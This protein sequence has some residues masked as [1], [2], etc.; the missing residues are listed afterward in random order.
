MAMADTAAIPVHLGIILDGNRRWAGAHGK[1]SV[2]GHREGAEVFKTVA[3]GAFERG[4]KYLSAFVFST[5]NWSRTEDE[6]GYLMKLVLRAVE[7]YL[8]EFHQQGIKIIIL[9]RREGV[10]KDVLSAIAKAEE[11]TAGNTKG[12]L[13]LCFNYG[14]QEE[15]V[16]AVKVLITQGT[17]A[18]KIDAA[19]LQ[20]A[21]YHPEVPAIDLI[22]RT[23]G[24]QRLSGFMLWRAAYAELLFVNKHWPDFGLDDLDQ[25]LAEY[26]KR[27]RRFGS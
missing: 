14:G 10:A 15:L 17:A 20:A 23:S 24:E 21:L 2:E 8:D 16:D 6:V 4:V 22:I 27:N 1:P 11:K 12:T 18:E 9:G 26:Q 5:E 3:L 19:A 25:A 7:K 13:A